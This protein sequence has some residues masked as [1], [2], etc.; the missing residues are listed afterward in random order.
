MNQP[1]ERGH[2][3]KV[4]QELLLQHLN[5]KKKEKVMKGKSGL[6]RSRQYKTVYID[7][8]KSPEQR[9]NEANLRLLVNTVAKDSLHVKGSRIV[10]KNNQLGEERNHRL[11]RNQLGRK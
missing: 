7:H 1:K 8:D 9:R 10:K 2:L 4:K 6:G 5:L 3:M 11:T